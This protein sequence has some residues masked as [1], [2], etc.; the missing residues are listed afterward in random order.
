MIGSHRNALP[1]LPPEQGRAPHVSW[2]TVG[3]QHLTAISTIHLITYWHLQRGDITDTL[4][5]C[6]HSLVTPLP[7]LPPVSQWITYRFLFFPHSVYLN[8]PSSP[9]P[10]QSYHIFSSAPSLSLRCHCWHASDELQYITYWLSWPTHIQNLT[11]LYLTPF[12]FCSLAFKVEQTHFHSEM[13]G[14][15][16]NFEFHCY[17]QLQATWRCT[18]CCWIW[19]SSRFSFLSLKTSGEF[20]HPSGWLTARAAA[21]HCVQWELCRLPPQPEHLSHNLL[22]MCNSSPDLCA[23]TVKLWGCFL[24]SVRMGKGREEKKANRI[25][26]V[27]ERG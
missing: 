6:C 22:Y 4:T 3:P 20:T 12:V 24:L 17:E 19:E 13:E 10:Q 8:P 2:A 21:R 1:F 25:S 27:M 26:F 9:A 15:R 23:K 11:F 18:H 7:Y 16:A 14:R 5:T